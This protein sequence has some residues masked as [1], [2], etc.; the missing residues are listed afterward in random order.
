MNILFAA[1][2]AHPLI[3]T[4]GLGDVIGS[5]PTTLRSLGED[6]RLILPAYPAAIA[7]INEAKG[8][9]AVI[10]HLTLPGAVGET[11][12][13]QA[14]FPGS[15]M[16]LYLIES[17]HYFSR[18]GGPY[19]HPDGYD[20]PDNAQRFA[21]F[22]RA[23]VEIAQ[24]RTTLNWQPDIVH[25]HDWQTGL[26]PALLSLESQRPTT[27]FT[28]HNLAYM[29]LFN[30]ETFVT[31]NP[32]E[33]FWS[34]EG[35]EFYGQ[36]SFLKGGMVYADWITTVSPTYANEILTP[37]FGYGFEGLLKHRS[38]RLVGILNGVDY[39]VWDPKNDTLIPAQFTPTN[40]TGKKTCKQALQKHV[41]LA[42]NPNTPLLGHVGRMVEQKGMDLLAEVLPR[43]T[44]SDIQIVILG[45]GEAHIQNALT[46]L[47]AQFPN[48]IRV[49]IGYS[50]EL[51]HLIE[52][53]ADMFLMPSRFEPCGLNQIYSLRYGTLPIVN[54][55]GG[56]ADTVI[57]ADQ[58]NINNGTATG[59][60]FTEA[61]P[62]A[63]LTAIERAL[64]LYQQPEIW[65]QQLMPQAM[66]QDFSWTRA[67]EQYLDLYRQAVQ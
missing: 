53:G 50:E 5:L 48:R 37:D 24:N 59:V 10:D 49:L 19:S 27:L 54:R 61:S 35:M 18:P 45:S 21:L 66:S 15:D 57:D 44:Q 56:L 43:L 62:Q 20:W 58:H 31:L 23:V 55:T 26:V 39:K 2:E 46:L 29:G 32:A 52:A 14:R 11:R 12:L 16:P 38:D 47:A 36:Y 7:L 6:V 25:A 1:S 17:E 60:C 51:A 3:K 65:R 28:I 8:E 30:N 22:A 64:M 4:G 33:H 34:H 63:L 40:L 42:E 41:G 13:L 67:A 9:L